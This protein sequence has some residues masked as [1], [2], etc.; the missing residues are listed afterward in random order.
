MGR[1]LDNQFCSTDMRVV[2]V[3]GLGAWLNG[4]YLAVHFDCTHALQGECFV[5]RMGTSC[6][7][8]SGSSGGGV[9]P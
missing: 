9:W 7:S 3:Q 5:R 6:R 8:G 2:R 4:M 1:E